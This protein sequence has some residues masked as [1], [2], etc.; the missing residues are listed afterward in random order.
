MHTS[1]STS[2]SSVIRIRPVDEV[3]FETAVRRHGARIARLLPGAEVTHVGSTAV[4]GALTKGDVDLMVRVA[5]DELEA[6]ARA[7]SGAYAIHQPE[8]WSPTFA[9]FLD[10]EAGDPPVG[11]QLV[12]EGS[13][14]EALFEPFLAALRDDP[15]LLAEYNALK[16]RLDGSDYELYTRAKGEFIE[17]VLA[18]DESAR[19]RRSKPQPTLEE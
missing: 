6:A 17:R 16:R 2:E 1:K 5:A 13:K 19:P 12:A 8:N 7:L 3:A 18:S 11:V 14:D 15:E 9:S 10:A 4:P